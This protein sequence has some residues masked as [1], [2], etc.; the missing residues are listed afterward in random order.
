MIDEIYKSYSLICDGCG[1]LI[2]VNTFDEA[3]DYKKD[4][5]WKSIKSGINRDDWSD[6]CPECREA[7]NEK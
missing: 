4:N 6:Y 5:N 2:E 3:V 7:Y 1:L